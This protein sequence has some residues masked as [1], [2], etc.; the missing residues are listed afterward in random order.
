MVLV[1]DCAALPTILSG[2]LGENDLLTS[3]RMFDF[4]DE[5]FLMVMLLFNVGMEILGSI[6][7]GI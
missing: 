4:C 2:I 6:L 1:H 7:I 3:R 5:C